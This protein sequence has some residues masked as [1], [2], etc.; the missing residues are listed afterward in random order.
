MK[1][2]IYIV[3]A[4]CCSVHVSAQSL[5]ESKEGS[6]SIL[7]NGS[8][9]TLKITEPALKL[10]FQKNKLFKNDRNNGYLFGVSAEG[11]NG[12]GIANIFNEGNLVPSGRITGLAGLTFSNN[13]VAVPQQ[14]REELKVKEQRLNKRW[15]ELKQIREGLPKDSKEAAEISQKMDTLVKRELLPLLEEGRK[16]DQAYSKVG[17]YKVSLFG[18][19][20][21][22]AKSFRRFTGFESS[23]LLK[24]FKNENFRGSFYGLGVNHQYRNWL[25]GIAMERRHDDNQA[26]LSEQVYNWERTT[27]AGNQTINESKEIKAYAGA[28]ATVS[29]FSFNADIVANISLDHIKS[30]DQP[31]NYMLINPYVHAKTGSSD[32]DLLPNTTD[33]GLGIYVFNDKSKLLGGIFVELPDVGDKIEK[34]KAVT[35]RN[36]RPALQ[37][38]SFGIVTRFNLQSFIRFQDL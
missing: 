29:Y 30:V 32:K 35:D 20:G 4:V 24:S 26:Y 11:K 17:F 25:F 16:A 36:I 34:S 37:K 5:T 1:K 28:Y 8:A 22:S 31:R 27:T 9:I 15:D 2:A 7:M 21:I 19:G 38:L 23:N 18:Y 14:L 10:D 12:S 13:V 33:A 3:L 6:N